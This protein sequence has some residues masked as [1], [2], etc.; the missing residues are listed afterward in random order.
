ME[1][2][3]LSAQVGDRGQRPRKAVGKCLFL[4]QYD[5]GRTILSDINPLGGNS[6]LVAKLRKLFIPS[7]NKCTVLQSYMS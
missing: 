7:A 3:A 6:S 5:K 2:G 1:L 4:E